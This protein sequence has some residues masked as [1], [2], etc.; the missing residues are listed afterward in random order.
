[1]FINGDYRNKP[2]S[3]EVL[4]LSKNIEQGIVEDCIKSDSNGMRCVALCVF[5]QTI[6]V[7]SFN[8]ES[9]KPSWHI[10]IATSIAAREENWMTD[11]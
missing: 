1:M 8:G 2:N 4:H 5:Q 3:P 7:S 9:G 10:M 11:T 6:F